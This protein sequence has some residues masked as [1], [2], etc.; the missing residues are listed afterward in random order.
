M[1]AK[2]EPLRYP[3]RQLK[4]RSKPGI[5]MGTGTMRLSVICLAGFLCLLA[6]LPAL[7]AKEVQTVKISRFSAKEYG[8]KPSVV[9]AK[10]SS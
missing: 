8:D 10:S 2:A 3:F 7:E 4:A 1:L 9:T 5:L 6:G